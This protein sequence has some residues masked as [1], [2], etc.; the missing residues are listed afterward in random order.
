MA[1]AIDTANQVQVQENR[2]ALGNKLIRFCGFFLVLS[3]AVK[4]VHPPGA[5]TYMDSMGF[6]G[7]TFYFIAVLELL[8]AV[9]FLIPSTRWLGLL[10]I[11][12]HLG[13]AIAAHLAAHRLT[14]GGPFLVFMATHPFMGALVPAAVLVTGWLGTWLSPPSFCGREIRAI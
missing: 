13:G 10:F 9:L 6:T 4:F 14:A 12:S 2:S 7:G 3:A 1:V 8:S 11:S 5:V